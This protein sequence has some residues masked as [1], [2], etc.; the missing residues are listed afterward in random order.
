MA[1]LRGAD[2]ELAADTNARVRDGALEGS[3]VVRSRR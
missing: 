2:G 1:S 3:N